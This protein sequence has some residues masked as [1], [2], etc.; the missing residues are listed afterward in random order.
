MKNGDYA[1]VTPHLLHFLNAMNRE[2]E[3][4]GF[5]LQIVD[6]MRLFTYV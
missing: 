3:A 1:R 6:F 2:G 4:P 5:D